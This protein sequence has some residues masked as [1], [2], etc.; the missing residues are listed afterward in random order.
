MIK[1]TI[2]KNIMIKIPKDKRDKLWGILEEEIQSHAWKKDK[3]FILKGKRKKFIRNESGYKIF[4]VD[5]NRIRNNISC[6]FSHGWHSLVHEFIPSNEIWI[7]SH[8]NN[9]NTCKELTC[10]CK[11]RTKWQ[12]VS[13]NYFD[14]T[15]IHEITEN[16]EM[17]KWKSYR[18]SHNIAL[19]KERQIGLLLDP[20]TDK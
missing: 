20:Y 7:A 15:T 4:M 1:N 17:K 14:S 19:E 5:W 18:E 10:I 13:K 16:K 9:K 11:T 12:K 2:S 6:Y 8:H 3:T